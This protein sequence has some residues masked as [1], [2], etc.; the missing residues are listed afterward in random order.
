MANSV[1]FMFSLLVSSNA[2]VRA[3]EGR[4]PHG[5]AS[6]IPSA[7]AASP[8]AYTFFNPGGSGGG[9]QLN[10]AKAAAQ[11][12]AVQSM[13]AAARGAGDGGMAAVLVGFLIVLVLAFGVYLLSVV[14][15][16]KG[17][18]NGPLV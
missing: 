10:Y 5:L 2:I 15:T 6:E 8:E 12:P 11:F 14:T 18:R 13:P 7:A 3:Q 16:Q 4:P 9:D 17:S 1:V